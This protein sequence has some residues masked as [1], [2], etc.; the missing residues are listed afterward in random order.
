[1]VSLRDAVANGDVGAVQKAVRKNGRAI[2]STVTSNGDTPLMWAVQ[3]NEDAQMVTWFIGAGAALDAQN[4]EGLTALMV[5]SRFGRTECMQLLIDAGAN[6]DIQDKEGLTAVMIACRHGKLDAARILAEQG[7]KIDTQNDDGRTALVFA[8]ALDQPRIAQMLIEHDAALDLQ[9]GKG[10][11]A[12]MFASLFDQT[13]IAQMLIDRGANID[14]QNAEGWTALM[15]ACR[16]DQPQTAQRLIHCNAKLDLENNHGWNALMCSCLSPI[17]GSQTRE[18]LLQALQLCWIAGCSIDHK[19]HD[20]H[21]ALS[22]ARHF[23]RDDAVRFIEF[24]ASSE[25]AQILLHELSIPRDVVVAFYKEGF[26]SAHDCAML[27]DGDL[28]KMGVLDATKRRNIRKR[29]KIARTLPR[30]SVGK[31]LSLSMAGYL[32]RNS[33]NFV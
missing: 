26:H 7:A 20:G 28:E 30:K 16:Y 11:T 25:V 27:F 4:N 6:I 17:Q 33:H 12:L 22:M 29:F 19:N 9:D 18:G 31:R 3:T 24:I 14:L 15:L 32:R 10:Y 23:K 13:E 2:E 1:M 5:A 8:C 21:D